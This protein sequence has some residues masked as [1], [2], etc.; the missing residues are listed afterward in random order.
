MPQSEMT[1]GR[2]LGPQDGPLDPTVA[3]FMSP[4]AA[5]GHPGHLGQR[6]E[7]EKEIDLIIAAT[8][9]FHMKPAD[10]VMRE[11]SA[12]TARLTE[13]CVLLHR[14]EGTDRRWARIRTMQ[15][16]KILEEMDRQWKTASR[17]IEVNRQDIEITR[18]IT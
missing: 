13:F 2:H 17:L 6:E 8:R 9:I 7:I 14:V 3:A 4:V 5:L 11:C 15:V 18:G 12:Y 16:Q 10:L 1:E